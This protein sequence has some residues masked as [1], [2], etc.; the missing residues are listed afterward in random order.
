MPILIFK[1]YYSVLVN[2][3]NDLLQEVVECDSPVLYKKGFDRY[4]DRMDVI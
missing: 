2:F 3:G 4:I 1:N